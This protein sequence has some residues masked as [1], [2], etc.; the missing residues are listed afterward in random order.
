MFRCLFAVIKENN[1]ASSLRRQDYKDVIYEF[2]FVTYC[3]LDDNII[4]V[5]GVSR[6]WCICSP[7]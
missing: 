3:T 5:L 2:N 6:K 7:G 1:Y 4:I